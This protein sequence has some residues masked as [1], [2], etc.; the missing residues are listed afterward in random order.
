M[1]VFQAIQAIR[2]KVG[3]QLKALGDDK[4]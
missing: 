4:Y 1:S 3:Q 2:T